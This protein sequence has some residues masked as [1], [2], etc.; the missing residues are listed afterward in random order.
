[1]APLFPIY[2]K[3][4]GVTKKL[5][6][7]LIDF[8]KSINP[9][10]VSGN[11]IIL[12]Q[13]SLNELEALNQH[14]PLLDQLLFP[15]VHGLVLTI[16]IKVFFAFVFGRPLPYLLLGVGIDGNLITKRLKAPMLEILNI[17]LF[18]LNIY[19]LG[20]ILPFKSL[21]SLLL[22]INLCRT[23]RLMGLIGPI[24]LFIVTCTLFTSP[25]AYQSAQTPSTITFKQLPKLKNKK[26]DTQNLDFS[27]KN[28]LIPKIGEMKIKK[29][30]KK[31]K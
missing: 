23:S 11:E 29:E 31:E 26:V 1:M 16:I 8:I 28:L 19:N 25:L 12:F 13:K 6:A 18:P 4:N 10:F 24:L 5:D 20:G 2:A 14:S 30:M 9:D 7:I 22:Q 15:V 17:I 21:P 3:A 27:G